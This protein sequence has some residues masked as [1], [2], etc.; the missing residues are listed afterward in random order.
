MLIEEGYRQTSI[1]DIATTLQMSPANI[2]KHFRSKAEL[3]HAVI[4]SRFQVRSR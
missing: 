4:A 3:A 1:A 2:F